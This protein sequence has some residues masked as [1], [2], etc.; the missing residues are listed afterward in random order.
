MARKNA[1]SPHVDTLFYPLHYNKDFVTPSKGT[2][3]GCLTPQ[4]IGYIKALLDTMCKTVERGLSTEATKL[5]PM[6]IAQVKLTLER[7]D[8]VSCSW[9]NAVL[10]YQACQRTLAECLA[11]MTYFKTHGNIIVPIAQQAIG[12][13]MGL[14][15]W[16][17]DVAQRYSLAGCPVWLFRLESAIPS[18]IAIGKVLS[19]PTLSANLERLGYLKVVTDLASPAFHMYEKY[20]PVEKQHTML[21]FLSMRTEASLRTPIPTQALDDGK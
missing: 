10:A 7:I 12:A 9:N 8:E 17:V 13:Y 20:A 3:Y 14:F 21:R 19:E 18:Q 16:D 1:S 4:S 2:M 15:T 11:A 5:V 6:L